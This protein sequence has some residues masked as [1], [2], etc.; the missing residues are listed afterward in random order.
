MLFDFY[1]NEEEGRNGI[2]NCLNFLNT[3]NLASPNSMFLQFFFQGKSNELVKIFS[4]AK[5]DV[6]DRA[7]NHLLKLDVTNTS[8][9][10]S[11]K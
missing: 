3:I 5:K 7:L 9:Y 10:N 4:K 11:L 2:F 1:D 8:I 6:R